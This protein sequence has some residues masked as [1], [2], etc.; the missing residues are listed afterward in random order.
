MTQPRDLEPSEAKG[1]RR[2]KYSSVPDLGLLLYLPI[3]GSSQV[4]KSA[5]QDLVLILLG[6]I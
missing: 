1:Q 6:P 4:G 2:K 3:A 5:C